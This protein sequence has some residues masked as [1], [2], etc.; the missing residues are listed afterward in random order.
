M[1]TDGKTAYLSSETLVDLRENGR[2]PN[3]R[4]VVESHFQFG[5]SRMSR[6][7]YMDMMRDNLI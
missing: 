2:L 1:R 7:L 4:K 6:A 3:D 5:E